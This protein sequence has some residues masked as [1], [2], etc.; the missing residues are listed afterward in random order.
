MYFVNLSPIS[1]YL[2]IKTFCE[3]KNNV[4]EITFLNHLTFSFPSYADYFPSPLVFRKMY[5]PEEKP[6]NK[7][8]GWHVFTLF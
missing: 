6:F 8:L 4:P 5:F 3:G 7:V 1:C 2:Q